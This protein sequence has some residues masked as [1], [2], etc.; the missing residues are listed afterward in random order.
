MLNRIEEN[1][2]YKHSEKTLCSMLDKKRIKH[3]QN[4]SCRRLKLET[5]LIL[6]L[7]CAHDFHKWMQ[8]FE[9]E[10]FNL[11]G[12]FKSWEAQETSENLMWSIR[13]A[14]EDFCRIGQ[15]SSMKFVSICELILSNIRSL[16]EEMEEKIA[17][18]R[19]SISNWISNLFSFSS[20]IEFL[21][22]IFHRISIS[23][24][25]FFWLHLLFLVT[26]VVWLKNVCRTWVNEILIWFFLPTMTLKP[27]LAHL[28]NFHYSF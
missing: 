22:R 21:L 5:L 2:S 9:E 6:G 19:I 14:Q 15:K 16:M 23:I 3:E 28:C 13:K 20:L 12:L 8:I 26:N 10:I 18:K 11:F 24:C 4:A 1:I 17:L 27:R 25:N 7:L